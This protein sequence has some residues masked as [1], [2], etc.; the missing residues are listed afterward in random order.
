MTRRA[1]Y[2]LVWS[3]PMTAI[4]AGF[5][6]S[7]NGLAKICDRMLIPYPT[8]G[9]WAK[10]YAGKDEAQTALP[11]AP[12][13]LP[14]EVTIAPGR[15]RSR[16][17]RKRLSREDRRKQILTRAE[18]LVREEGVC[19]VSMKR[20]ARDLGMSEAQ[21][22]N[23]YCNVATLLAAIARAELTAMNMARLAASRTCS[24]PQMRYALTTIAYLRQVAKRGE[25]LQQLLA[26]PEVRRELRGEHE[27]R[28]MANREKLG[29][30]F[31]EAYG[32]PPEI[33]IGVGAMLTA[34]SLRGGRMLAR[35]KID[36]ETA[37]RLVM[38]ITGGVVAGM[39][40]RH[41][42]GSHTDRV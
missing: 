10:V 18:A 41:G 1:F 24:D 9:Y 13:G 25:L 8:R 38:P 29:N 12:A 3:Q 14:N 37:E 5:G 33:S 35:G 28:R 26:V 4:A 7:A 27:D 34:L 23:Y 32:V 19:F 11:G 36:L 2:D 6:L 15:S 20:I 30:V 40:E 31:S 22:Y 17:P 21:I 16:R 42:R 39:L